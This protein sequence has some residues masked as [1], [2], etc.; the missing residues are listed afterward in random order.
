MARS[1]R[2]TLTLLAPWLLAAAPARERDTPLQL[3]LPI[4]C[5]FGE[6]FPRFFRRRFPREQRR[7]RLPA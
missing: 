5:R 2:L 6:H 1:A 4:R 3:D 7:P